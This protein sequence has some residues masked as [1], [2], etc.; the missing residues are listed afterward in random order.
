MTG[1]ATFMKLGL[2]PANDGHVELFG[3][4]FGGI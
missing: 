4:L 1:V 3:S 2:A